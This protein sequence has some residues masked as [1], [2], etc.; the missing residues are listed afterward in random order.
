M[1]QVLQISLKEQGILNQMFIIFQLYLLHCSIHERFICFNFIFE[2]HK[3]H[4][5][6]IWSMF[7]LSINLDSAVTLGKLITEI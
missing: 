4:V 6:I 5:K 1:I 3:L 2:V 7:N